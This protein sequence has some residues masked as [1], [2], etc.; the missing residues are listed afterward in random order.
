[1]KPSI[2]GLLAFVPVTLALEHLHAPHPLVFFSAG[3]NRLDR[4]GRHADA[5]A[6]AR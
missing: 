3:L 5:P 6:S 1:M 4:P 2:N